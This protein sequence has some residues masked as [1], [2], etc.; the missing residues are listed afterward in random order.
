MIEEPEDDTPSFSRNRKA[1][2]LQNEQPKDETDELTETNIQLRNELAEQQTLLK[3]LKKR[4]FETYKQRKYMKT[5]V[6][7]NE[8][9]EKI[10]QGLD[11]EKRQWIQ[12][13]Q[14][15]KQNLIGQKK[16]TN[17]L[18][19]SSFL[20][21]VFIHILSTDIFGC[22]SI[23]FFFFFFK[24]CNIIVDHRKRLRYK[25]DGKSS[26]PITKDETKTNSDKKN[27]SK[28]KKYRPEL[29]FATEARV[30][31]KCG[32]I[33]IFFEMFFFITS[34]YFLGQRGGYK[35]NLTQK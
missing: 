5:E 8:V 32:S 9:L 28:T 14:F 1:T 6:Y 26:I 27:T 19:P 15:E 30:L 24:L 23:P 10:Q 22:S 25:L 20:S 16:K 11:R 2:I 29:S 4:I 17:T 12:L 3:D 7:Q 33:F 34:F 13:F 21:F 31:S 18:L 35:T